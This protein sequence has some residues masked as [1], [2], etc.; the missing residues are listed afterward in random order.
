[1]VTKERP[2]C[3]KCGSKFVYVRINGDVVCRGCGHVEKKA[4]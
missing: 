4:G 1:M 3:K 2:I